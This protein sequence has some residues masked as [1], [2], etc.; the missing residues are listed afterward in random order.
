[1]WKKLNKSLTDV[2]IKF[3]D[4]I[5]VL[6]KWNSPSQASS[7]CCGLC[8]D[9][10]TSNVYSPLTLTN[11]WVLSAKA[12]SSIRNPMYCFLY[13]SICALKNSTLNVIF[14][15]WLIIE[16][17]CIPFNLFDFPTNVIWLYSYSRSCRET[18]LQMN[19]EVI[20][21]SQYIIGAKRCS[22]S[23]C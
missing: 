4:D 10:W 11:V 7:V 15:K 3:Q 1:M 6:L 23:R 14:F 16:N 12:T 8:N 21:E 5:P 2:I 19:C 22:V 17:E 20:M 13:L 18:K 9:L